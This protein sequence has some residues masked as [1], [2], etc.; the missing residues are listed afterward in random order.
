MTNKA[1]PR[2]L[3]RA[4]DDVGRMSDEEFVAFCKQQLLQRPKL[5]PVRAQVIDALTDAIFNVVVSSKGVSVQEIED[6]LDVVAVNDPKP[7]APAGAP[8]EAQIVEK[9]REAILAHEML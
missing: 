6:R 3:A 9:A 2:K 1:T 4:A 8:T 5:A 7:K